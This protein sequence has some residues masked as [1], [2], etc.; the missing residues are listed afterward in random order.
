MAKTGWQEWLQAAKQA[1]VALKEKCGTVAVCGLSM[2]GLLA[3]L[4]AGQVRVNA[5]IPISTPMA[6]QNKWLRLAGIAAPFYPRV[7]WPLRASRREGV[8]KAYDYG[9]AGFPTRSAADLYHLIKLTRRN[10]SAVSCPILCVQSADDR[11]IW[12]G[13]ADTILKSVSSRDK[14]KLLLYGVPHVATL[15]VELPTIVKAVDSLMQKIVTK[16]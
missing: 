14:Q 11:T 6:T 8:D 3:L 9:Y 16:E 5:C 15:S 12:Q 4:A 7:A 10:L 13:S 1:T 2:G